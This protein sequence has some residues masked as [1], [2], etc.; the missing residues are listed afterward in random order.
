MSSTIDQLSEP[1]RTALALWYDTPSFKAYKK[2][3]ELERINLA[4]K[5]VDVSPLDTVTISKHQ[6]RADAYKQINLILA[7]NYKVMNKES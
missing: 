7:K 2:L 1:E 4:T 6:G 5:L 3:L